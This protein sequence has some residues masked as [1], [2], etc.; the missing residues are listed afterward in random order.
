MKH[1]RIVPNVHGVNLEVPADSVVRFYFD[2]DH[3]IDVAFDAKDEC[4]DIKSSGLGLPGLSIRPVTGNV[5]E[6]HLR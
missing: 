1:R 5:V 2:G 6:V 4:L 3:Y